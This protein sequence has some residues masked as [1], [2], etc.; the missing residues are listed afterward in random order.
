MVPSA[1]QGCW[2]HDHF[3]ILGPLHGLST[4]NVIC[5][6]SLLDHHACS[7]HNVLLGNS[8]WAWPAACRFCATRV[9]PLAPQYRNTSERVGQPLRWSLAS[10]PCLCASARGPVTRARFIPRRIT[11]LGC[12]SSLYAPDT[13]SAGFLYAMTVQP[14]TSEVRTAG[15]LLG[16]ISMNLA[17]IWV[18]PLRCAETGGIRTERWT[19]K[20]DLTPYP[21]SGYRA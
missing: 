14:S 21:C 11:Y 13:P 3:L 10:E 2:W 12:F 9:A 6:A 16:K 5:V 7:S 18:M 19:V 4:L 1:Q 20:C 15:S 8:L 17:K